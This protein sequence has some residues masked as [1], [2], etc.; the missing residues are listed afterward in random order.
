MAPLNV[1]PAA[2]VEAETTNI[3]AADAMPTITIPT[4]TMNEATPTITKLTTMMNSNLDVV[5]IDYIAAAMA[6][7]LILSLRGDGGCNG[8]SHHTLGHHF[9]K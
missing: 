4:T 6:M 1:A 7:M 8:R 2:D 5:C 9:Q 3:V